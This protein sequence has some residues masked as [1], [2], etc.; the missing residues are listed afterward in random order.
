MPVT[1][2][3]PQSPGTLDRLERV[4][5]WVLT[6][7]LAATLIGTTLC[8]GGYL[9]G[10]MVWTSRALWGLAALGG[11]LALLRPRRLNWA[12]LLPVPFLLYALGSTLWLAPAPWLAWREWLLWFQMWLVF[13][14]V[15]HFGRTRSQTAV[16]VLGFAG[17]GLTGVV[18]A[19]W[20]RY[21]DPSWMMLGRTQA[22][23]FVGRSAGMFG[24]PNSL[25]GL[26]ELMIPLLL[27]WSA[28]RSAR[29]TTRI[30]CYWLAALFLF[31]LVLTGSRGGWIATCLAICAWPV[32]AGRNWRK[33]VFGSVAVLGVV[34]AGLAAL[35]H[36]SDFAR[37]RIDPFLEGKFEHT[38]P[39]IWQVGVDLWRDAPW[40]G[41]GAA[42]YN[43]LFD[44]HRPAGF[45]YEPDWTHNDYL[46]TLSDYG[47]AGF[48]LWMAAGIAVLALGWRA[49]RGARREAVGGGREDFTAHWRWLFGLWLGLLA[50]V[51]HLAVDFHTK[52]PALAFAGAVAAALLLRQRPSGAPAGLPVAVRMV[53]FL[54]CLA[55]LVAAGRTADPLY[56]AEDLRF[57]HRRAINQQARG[58]DTLDRVLPPALAAFQ[59][60]VKIDPTNGQAWGDLSYAVGL[61]WHVTRGNVVATGRRAEAAAREA[62]A[63]CAVVA[64]FWV[65]L[66]VALDMQARQEEAETCY[67]RALELAP[68]R[69]EWHYYLAYHLSARPGRSEEALPLLET[70]LTL[71]P[72]FQQAE[73]LR[74]RL[75][76]I[77]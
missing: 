48:A 50:Y 31:A 8:L 42:S 25:A 73:S 57:H 49:W 29:T 55:A 33:G 16:W 56:R 11:L 18:M 74:V 45:N 10:T 40:I 36:F 44:Q 28:A 34:W 69:A 6:L 41:T 17:L 39:L 61:S 20:Q 76:R 60:A 3:N 64:E 1:P 35:Y 43:V 26:L 51:A 62:I 52:I 70:C 23:Q 67:R 5:E 21:V 12:V 2:L 4:G 19:A 14:L 59:Q 38:R 47:V 58:Q 71:D 63:R 27:V 65:C 37:V 7:G 32:L 75:L 66:G 24:I 77:P 68:T 72:S 15:L 46:N 30:V 13:A 54:L 22:G 9:A 53:L